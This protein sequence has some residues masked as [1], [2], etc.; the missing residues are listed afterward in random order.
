MLK[1]APEGGVVERDVEGLLVFTL[2]LKGIVLVA[3]L[4]A[5]YAGKETIPHA[6]VLLL[7]NSRGMR[8]LNK[9][10]VLV[11]ARL[12]FDEVRRLLVIIA[13]EPLDRGIRS[14][15]AAVLHKPCDVQG[16]APRT[17]SSS[18]V[19]TAVTA[20]SVHTTSSWGLSRILSRIF[21][22]RAE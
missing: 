3:L 2:H 12:L 15:A 6:N 9:D 20:R 10:V 8:A 17:G 21:G 18:S 4:L 1:L 19:E 11:P 14:Q 13:H 16:L 7:C 22:L 5:L